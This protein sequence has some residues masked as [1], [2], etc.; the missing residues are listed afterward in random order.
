MAEGLK[1]VSPEYQERLDRLA[2]TLC[3]PERFGRTAVGQLVMVFDSEMGSTSV[4]DTLFD[5][6]VEFPAVGA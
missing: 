4:Q 6:T 2:E 1:Y 5:D 3:N